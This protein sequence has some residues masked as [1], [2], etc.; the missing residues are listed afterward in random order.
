MRRPLPR[1]ATTVLIIGKLPDSQPMERQ[2][3]TKTLVTSR[4][5]C[6]V[7]PQ[8]RVSQQSA[9]ATRTVTSNPRFRSRASSSPALDVQI[10][11]PGGL[12][13]AH[14]GGDLPGRV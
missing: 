13:R 14:A 3:D 10:G 12:E 4:F 6:H 1:H 7:M 8:V 9:L 2:L 5:H 11:E